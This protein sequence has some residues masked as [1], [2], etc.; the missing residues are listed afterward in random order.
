MP[1]EKIDRRKFLYLGAGAVVALAAAGVGYLYRSKQPY[2]KT[3]TQTTVSTTT[4]TSPVTTAKPPKIISLEYK[5]T[6]VVNDKVYDINV[7]LAVENSSRMLKE[8][9]VSLFPVE[10]PHLPKEAFPQEETRKAQLQPRNLDKEIFS[11]DFTD[12]KGGREYLVKATAKNVAGNITSKEEKKTPY[13]RQFENI[14]PL[15][16]LTVTADYYFGYRIPPGAWQQNSQKIHVYMPLLGE[17][18]S[19]DPIVISKHIDWATGHRIDA[20]TISWWGTNP[21]GI[22][23]PDIDLSDFE[24]AFLNHPLLKDIKF[25]IIYENTGRLKIKNPSDPPEKWVQDLDNHFNRDRLLHDFEYI[26]KY[27]NSPSYL[28]VN[29]KPAIIFDYTACFR[30]DIKSV[31]N[32]L[33]GKIREKGWDLYLIN[34]IGSRAFYPED[35]INKNNPHILQIIDSTDS[36]GYCFYMNPDAEKVYKGWHDFAIEHGKGF[37]PYF[38]AGFE[39]H[40]LVFPYGPPVPYNSKIFERTINASIKY[41]VHGIIGTRF[42]AWYW[43]SHIEPAVEYGFLYL[44]MINYYLNKIVK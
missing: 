12:L 34:D 4:P 15:D 33:R 5:P 3:A 2:A 26:T 31:F 40:P 10:Y 20:F 35:I 13:I 19:R 9:E 24:T 11:V 27:F 29:G 22:S 1:D 30:G 42:N 7:T 25:F 6:K 28:K 18:D 32:K 17:Y 16:G 43:G 14:A 23:H 38:G 44:D 36:I 37:L 21:A 41:N 8:A 39:P